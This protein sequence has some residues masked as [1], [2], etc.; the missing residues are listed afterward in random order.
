M[1]SPQFNQNLPNSPQQDNRNNMSIEELKKKYGGDF[2]KDLLEQ[3]KLYV[4]MAD[5]ISARR[6]QMNSFY[7]T[8]L[9]G[10]LAF[11]S[12]LGNKDISGFQKANVQVVGILAVS[13]LG[14]I[15]CLIW[16]FNIKSYKQLNSGKFKVIGEMEKCMPFP[17]YDREWAIIKND[18]RYQGF[19]TQTQVEKNLPI[20]LAIPYVGLFVY[21]LITLLG[22]I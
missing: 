13:I 1:S 3:Y 8:L 9:T 4:E 7:I 19:V 14:M 22:K 6:A 2:H 15:L 17:C 10:L 16:Y 11:I 5:R 21:A 20:I 18:K 12:I